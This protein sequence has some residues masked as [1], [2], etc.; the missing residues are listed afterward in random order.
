MGQRGAQP[1]VHAEAESQVFIGVSHDIEA[2]RF[3][4]HLVVPVGGDYDR[5]PDAPL[6]MGTP[7]MTVSSVAVRIP[8]LTGVNRGIV[9]SVACGI[10][11][12]GSSV[13]AVGG[14]WP[15]R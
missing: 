14:I 10:R 8:C 5:Y 2:K 4:E 13:S 1:Q 12:G 6:G 15:K 7:R 9:A 3:V 11:S